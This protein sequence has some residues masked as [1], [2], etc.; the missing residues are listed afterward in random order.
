MKTAFVRT[1]QLLAAVSLFSSPAQA[2]FPQLRLELVC[3]NQLLSPLGM[4]HAN[5]GSG[6]AFVVEQRGKIMIFKDRMLHPRP[7][8]DIG[9]KLVPVS[10]NY[11]ERGLLGLAFHPTYGTAGSP[12]HR[13]FYVFY[14]ESSP[15]APGP[16][17]NPVNCRTVISEFQASATDPNVADPT[18]ERVLLKF[19]KPQANH[20]GGAIEFGPDGFLYFSVG[21]GGSANDNNAGHTGGGSTRPTNAKGN[22]QDLTQIMGKIHR[23]DPLGTNGPGGQYGIPADNPYA[24]ATNGERPEIY[25]YGLRNCWRM[26]FDKRP[27]GTGRLF[28]ADV[29]QGSVEEVN[30]ITKGGNYGWRNKEGTFFPTFSV[31][32]PTMAGPAIDP[33][34]QY[35]HMGVTIGTPA[36]PQL[37]LSVTGGYIY[38]G[39]AIPALAGKYLFA[40]WS[41]QAIIQNAPPNATGRGVLLGLEEPS[42]GAAT[43]NLSQLDIVGGNPIQRYIQ[44]L[45]EDE[46]GEIYVLTKRVQPVNGLDGATGLP[47]GSIFKIVPVGTLSTINLN[48]AKDNTLYQEDEESNGAGAFIFAGNTK[49]QNN[50][51][52]RRAL[53]S[54]NF[55]AIPAGAQVAS[56]SLR[57]KMNKTVAGAFP[58]SLLRMNVNWGEGTTDA[59]TQEGDGT[60][61][62][63][64]DAT[65]L[66]PFFGQAAT[67]DTPG[68]DFTATK[69]ATTSVT[70]TSGNFTWS[71]PAVAAD[72]T[73]WLADT[74]TNFGW[75]LKGDSETVKVSCTGTINTNTVVVESTDGLILGMRALGSGVRA[76]TT[77]TA[78]DTSSN[79]VTLAGTNTANVNGPVYF[80]PVNPTAKRFGS[81]TATVAADRPQLTVNYLP[82]APAPTTRRK[83]WEAAHYLVGQ[84][85]NDQYD[86]DGDGIVDGL[87]Y[88]FGYN[89]R[90]QRNPLPTGFQVSLGTQ[91]NTNRIVFRRDPAATDLTYTVQASSDLVS[92][93]TVA[94]SQAGAAT[95]GTAVVSET[96]VDTT[97]RQVTIEETTAP[98]VRRRIYRLKVDRQ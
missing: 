46:A 38:R 2:A 74:A 3:D 40:D 61:A 57:L 77:I 20:G 48:A 1:C 22:S 50:Y 44:S 75:M 4:T 78:I 17:T 34:G 25:A 23:I 7:F 64:T 28:G 88:A 49:A 94:L 65:W 98:T 72:V 58:F 24:N 33:I 27:G 45:G 73:S 41:Q 95:T 19:D 59:G 60:G 68:G 11:D 52:C 53:L 13:K 21:D 55:A 66:K 37:G 9:P 91:P 92:W 26:S 43:W 96:V 67:W 39:S 18:S 47:S 70:G 86:T 29:G 93:T 79:I 54:F 16:A 32:A 35:A 14:M 36:L 80:N 81:R 56:A 5:D 76:E 30:I 89:P 87:E 15:N 12:G 8:L 97:F 83:Q 71:G 69:S 63:A 85:I 31:D 42:P 90:T 62:S 6:R 10:P 82:P 84:F 51:A